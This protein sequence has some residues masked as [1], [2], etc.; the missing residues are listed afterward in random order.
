MSRTTEGAECMLDSEG[1]A[2]R[3]SA[4]KLTEEL[5]RIG[6]MRKLM[7]ALVVLGVFSGLTARAQVKAPAM[8]LGQH[9]FMYTG[10]SHQRNIFIVRGGK[11]VWSYNDVEAKG[12]I[13]DS[14]ML[15]NGNI[16]Y[17]HQFGVKLITPEKKVLWHYEPPAGFDPAPARG[18]PAGATAAAGPGSSAGSATPPGPPLASSTTSGGSTGRAGPG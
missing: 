16:L 18:R 6:M 8:G 10:E 11:V 5:E 3:G 12:E 7:M 4:G 2:A 13:S 15:S 14:V 17:A 9:D 1:K